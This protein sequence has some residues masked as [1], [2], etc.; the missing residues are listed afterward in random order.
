[1]SCDRDVAICKPLHYV[2]IM[3]TR[4]CRRL[5]LSCWTAGLLVILPPFSLGLNMEFCDSGVIDHYICSAYP[6][7]KISCTETWLL[8]Q[9]ILVCAELYFIITLVCVVLS[10]TYII[11]TI[12]Q[13]PSAQQRKKAF[14]TFSSHMIVISIT[15]RSCVFI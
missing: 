5:I 11:K 13:F 1:M 2:T 10:Y 7:F 9:M 15:Y 6:L 4:V 14:S 12:L 8:E 3:N